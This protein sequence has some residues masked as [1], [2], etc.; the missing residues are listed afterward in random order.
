MSDPVMT[1]VAKMITAA[2]LVEMT[3]QYRTTEIWLLSYDSK[4]KKK[5]EQKN[6]IYDKRI[7]LNTK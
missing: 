5:L 1:K 4:D 7:F 6:K 3:E 2:I